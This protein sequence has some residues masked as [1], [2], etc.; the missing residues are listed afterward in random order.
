M[1]QKHDD[2]YPPSWHLLVSKEQ[3]KVTSMGRSEVHVSILLSSQEKEIDVE[4]GNNHTVTIAQ[5]QE[6]KI[7][8]NDATDLSKESLPN[9]TL[10]VDVPEK[11]NLECNLLEGGSITI[12]NKIEGDVRLHTQQ[13]LVQVKKLRGH[14]IDIVAT[15]IFAAQLLESQSLKLTIPQ[16][17][18][19]RAKRIHVCDMDIQVG[20]N[21]NN[22]KNNE[23]VDELYDNDVYD[24]DDDDDS[25]ATC[26]ISSLY[27]TGDAQ[28]MVQGP[29]KV[30]R[31][32]QQHPIRH[33]VRIKSHHGHINVQ[34]NT[35]I[36]TIKNPMTEEVMPVVDLGGVNGSCEVTIF[37]PIEPDVNGPACH[38]HFDSI[39]P[40]SVSLVHSNW[41]NVNVTTDRKVEADVRLL[42]IPKQGTVSRDRLDV[43]TLLLEDNENGTLADALTDMLQHLT[44]DDVASTTTC[45][46][47]GTKTSRINILSKAF[48]EKE[49]PEVGPIPQNRYEFVDGWVE[50]A[51]SEPDS[52]FDRKVRGIS[53]EDR[54][55]LVVVG[56]GGGKIRLEGAYNQALYGF[57]KTDE[58]DSSIPSPSQQRPLLAV[59]T[60]GNII[61][62]TLSWMGNIARRYG[63]V[64][65]KRETKD[66]GR[67]AT[68]RR[69]LE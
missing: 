17:G 10:V 15:T 57:Q 6:E 60:S 47:D 11:I 2:A 42:S 52:R 21:D 35:P 5:L 4:N 19:I 14:A 36:P 23:P 54:S 1:D 31:S 69:R 8:D 66:L 32:T 50:N 7:I 40:D 41:G 55:N 34:T 26:D 3:D 64:N 61:L 51:S 67:Q 38:I 12:D 13:G 53:S 29:S 18:R 62:E 37:V 45:T 20:G 9:P 25:G 63:I 16:Q 24:Y 43:E 58:R 68:R 46:T 44:D 27:I 28:V 22:V 56:G 49:R 48:T 33:A 30:S 65:D 39:V 59:V